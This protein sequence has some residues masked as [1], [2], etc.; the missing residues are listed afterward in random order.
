MKLRAMLDVLLDTVYI[1]NNSSG[2]ISDIGNFI[3]IYI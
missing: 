2:S 3:F 1:Q